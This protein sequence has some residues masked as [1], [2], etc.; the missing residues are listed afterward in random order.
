VGEGFDG[1]AAAPVLA[2]PLSRCVRVGLHV[3]QLGIGSP[4]RP[5][6]GVSPSARATCHRR[7]ISGQKYVFGP[8]SAQIGATCVL[9]PDRPMD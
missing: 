4:T 5:S 1:Q 3:W 2:G 9:R 7:S 8:E 6:L